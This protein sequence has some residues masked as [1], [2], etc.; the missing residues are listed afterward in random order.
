MHQSPASLFNF[1]IGGPEGEALRERTRLLAAS[2]SAVM[3]AESSSALGTLRRL[4]ALSEAEPRAADALARVILDRECDV[5]APTGSSAL[6]RARLLDTCRAAV[7]RA[8][9]RRAH[10]VAL[11]GS[12]IATWDA[13]RP[14]PEGARHWRHAVATAALCALGAETRPALRERAVAAGLLHGL[15]DL[16]LRLA[17]AEGRSPAV[18]AV[19]IGAQVATRLHLPEWIAPI[20]GDCG[21]A[22][23][24]DA[25]GLFR[26]TAAACAA[27]SAAGF[28]PAGGTPAAVASPDAGERLLAALRVRGG[29]ARLEREVETAFVA[30]RAGTLA[31]LEDAE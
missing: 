8:G 2:W 27:A 15:G 24:P 28:A 21:A 26:L 31:A 19:A 12:A 22:A 9:Y 17:R 14:G 3:A 16:A 11:A 29:A 1:N 6:D 20:A 23:A 25:G 5:R 18:A 10:S 4:L 13:P 30:A 7:G